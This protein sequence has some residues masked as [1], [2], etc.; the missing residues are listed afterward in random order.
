MSARS[1]VSMPELRGTRYRMALLAA[2]ALL[3]PRCAAADSITWKLEGVT[4]G[5]GGTA[6]GHFVY[7]PDLNALSTVDIVTS[8]PA[9]GSGGV[10]YI[11]PDPGDPVHCC[12]FAFVPN[13]A[14]TNFLGTP[15]L[16]LGIPSGGGFLTDSGGTF[17]I[18]G[19]EGLCA[20]SACFAGLEVNLIT[21]GSIT[22]V[23]EPPTEA[24]LVFGA[25]LL[26]I[27]QRLKYRIVGSN[28][29]MVRA[30]HAEDP[31]ALGGRAW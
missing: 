3:V 23:P 21:S 16:S 19:F 10:T 29:S 24:L 6:S 9:P 22:S 8:P 7:D 12:G 1:F 28:S 18:Q 26:Y 13:P 15:V 31:R 4:F 11:A 5:D 27:T 14:L 30:N 25:A 2:L 17:A 20:D